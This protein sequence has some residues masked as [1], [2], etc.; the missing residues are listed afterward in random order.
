MRKSKADSYAAYKEVL[1]GIT[2]SYERSGSA[3]DYIERI[4][5]EQYKDSDVYVSYTKDK[6]STS[7]Q[8]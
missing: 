6:T 8:D 1:D 5:S 2:K 7:S 4:K 3:T